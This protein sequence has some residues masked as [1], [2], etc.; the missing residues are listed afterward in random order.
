MFYVRFVGTRNGEWIEAANIETAKYLF[1]RK[2][3]IEVTSYI[4][5]SRKGPVD[6]LHQGRQ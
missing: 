2:H 3:G 1:A 4:V 6:H 5:A